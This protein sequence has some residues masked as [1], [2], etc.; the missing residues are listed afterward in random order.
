MINAAT[1]IA[2]RNGVANAILFANTNYGHIQV[3]AGG[4]TKQAKN[5]SVIG[6]GAVSVPLQISNPVES[7]NAL[8]YSIK[9]WLVYNLTFGGLRQHGRLANVTEA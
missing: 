7:Y 4:K 3:L 5:V 8:Q 1:L 9:A 6:D 2:D